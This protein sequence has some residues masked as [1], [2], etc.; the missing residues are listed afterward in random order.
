M[1]I[2]VPYEDGAV[3]QHFGRARQ[4]KLY[5]AENG[6]ITGERIQDTGGSGHGAL[7]GFLAGCGA[8]VLICGGIG[9]GA[10]DAL[11]GAGIQLRG[12]VSGGAD[13]AVKAFL[14]GTLVWDEAA[15]CSHHGHEHHGRCSEGTH[16]CGGHH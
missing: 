3:F 4:F 1:R 7:A 10:R 12:G 9:P 15:V 2:A 6:Q 16:G 11:A 5:D 14:A 13:E 8:E